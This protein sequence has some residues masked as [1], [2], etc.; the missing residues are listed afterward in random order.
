MLLSECSLQAGDCRLWARALSCAKV[1]PPPLLLLLSSLELVWQALS[2]VIPLR[3]PSRACAIHMMV[4][5]CMPADCHVKLLSS[6]PCW[7][8]LMRL[9]RFPLLSK[10]RWGSCRPSQGWMTLGYRRIPNSGTYWRPWIEK[11]W[12]L[13]HGIVMTFNSISAISVAK[14]FLL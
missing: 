4:A 8:A 13:Y 5:G 7:K 3:S 1:S 11:M 14:S 9:T 2:H 10:F 12:N 6:S